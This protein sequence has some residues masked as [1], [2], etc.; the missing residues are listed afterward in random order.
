MPGE[1]N[2]SGGS[3]IVRRCIVRATIVLI[4]IVILLTAIFS[5][6]CDENPVSEPEDIPGAVP[7]A[8]IIV[9]DLEG[10]IVLGFGQTV[11]VESEK[12]WI[13]FTDVFSDSRCPMDARCFWPGQA[14][15]E[16]V[17]EKMGSMEEPV[18]L[19]LQPGRNPL[20][21]SEM[22]ECACGY[23]IYFLALEPYPSVGKTIPE[24]SYIAQIILEPD[25]DC[26][27]E[28][29]VCFTWLSP[30]LLQRD[31]F[32][33]G[34]IS[35]EGDELTLQVSYGGGCREHGFK[36]YMQP[37]FAESNPVR[38][39]L[40]VSHNGN[41]DACEALISEALT[42]DLR[43]IA[44]LYYYQYGGYDDII[45]DVF[46]YFTDQRGDGLEVLYSP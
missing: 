4:A 22:F 1:L 34:G 5:I 41:G 29:E 17:L 31:P 12:L 11:Y 33:L 42:F 3:H 6:S 35:I 23:R 36:L 20:G 40:Y 7:V 2:Q 24:E 45:L 8:D 19:M 46:G 27:P 14:E 25:R 10:D 26:C 16:L 44:E 32:T 13:R 15:I 39:N 37:V 21:D 43:K 28:G 30:F 9:P 38:A 18:I